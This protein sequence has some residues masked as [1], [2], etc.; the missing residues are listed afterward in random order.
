MRAHAEETLRRRYAARRDQLK[1]DPY[2][3]GEADRPE[4]GAHPIAP[5]RGAERTL[6]A[7]SRR[8]RGAGQA[9]PDQAIRRVGAG[10]RPS[11]R[12]RGAAAHVARRPAASGPFVRYPEMR[13]PKRLPITRRSQNGWAIARHAGDPGQPHR[14]GRHMIPAGCCTGTI[15]RLLRLRKVASAGASLAAFDAWITGRKRST[16]AAR[17]SIS[18]GERGP[19]QD[20]PAGTWRAGLAR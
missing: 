4:T 1:A 17:R 12:I 3:P 2:A 16:A 9:Q 15:R 8:I 18:R 13:F 14:A 10:D 7:T 5:G 6:S 19:A 20:Q 11:A